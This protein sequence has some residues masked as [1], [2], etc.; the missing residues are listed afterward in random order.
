MKSQKERQQQNHR[1]SGKETM[2]TANF[3]MREFTEQEC[4]D[5]IN[6]VIKSFPIVKKDRLWID[7]EKSITLIH[8][9]HLPIYNFAYRSKDS[10]YVLVS[11]DHKENRNQPFSPMP[12]E[13]FENE[14]GFYDHRN[15]VYIRVHASFMFGKWEVN[16]DW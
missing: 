11:D 6:E 16:E 4:L 1:K 10:L 3:G 9:G 15:H 14:Q 13:Y 12:K 7:G 2:I 8:N 5:K